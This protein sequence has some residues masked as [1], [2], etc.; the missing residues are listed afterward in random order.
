MTEEKIQVLETCDLFVKK[1]LPVFQA[2]ITLI[3]STPSV[4]VP[5]IRIVGPRE[6]VDAFRALPK[7]MADKVVGDFLQKAFDR[8]NLELKARSLI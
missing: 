5:E 2:Q 6:D 1:G 8:G 7:K 4:G 3:L